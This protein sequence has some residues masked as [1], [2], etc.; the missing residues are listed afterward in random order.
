MG[1]LIRVWRSL[2]A[3]CVRDAKVE[4]SNLSTLTSLVRQKESVAE[5]VIPT[6]M[7]P[8]ITVVEYGRAL[9]DLV[10]A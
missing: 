3:R 2:V 1:F 9:T 4:S 5:T 7:V 10:D 8:R 6:P